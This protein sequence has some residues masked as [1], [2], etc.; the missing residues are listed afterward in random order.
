MTETHSRNAPLA[1]RDLAHVW[2][3]CTQMREHEAQLPLIPIVRGDGAWLVDA[4]G[5]RYLDGISSWWSCLFGH[6]NPRI[7]AAIAG[8]AA[9]LN[10]VMLAGFTHEPALQLAEELVRIAP[11]GLTRVSYASDGASA[12]EIALKMSFHYWRNA[13]Q[14]QRT[15]F[16]ALANAYHGETLGALAVSDLPLYREVYGPL[17][18]D[19]IVAPSPDWLDAEP[20]ESA[21]DVAR[22]RLVD[23]RA[24]LERHAHETCAVIV[25]PLVQCSGG[26]RMHAP[27]YLAGLRA[28]CDE[29]DV[30]LIADEIAVGF[31]RTGTLFACGQAAITP[32]FLCLSKGLTGGAL[33]LS[34]VLTT[35]TVY[36]AFLGNYADNNAFLHS[37][38]FSGNPIAC[39]AALASLSIFRDEPVLE[40]NRALAAH[41]AMRLRP[42][43]EH[44]HVANL[45]QTGWI[46]AFDL[47]RD[48]ATR[49]A[50]PSEERRG[51]RF[52]THALERGVLL[53]PL[54]DTVYFLPPYCI[55]SNDVDF[56]VDAAISAI[57]FATA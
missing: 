42:L 27:A 50:W 13:G 28:L 3:P 5:R 15:R 53:R 19:P 4:D 36:D 21:D 6:A 20:G 32:D 26:M 1:A 49:T 39:A 45:R 40:R 10:H 46:A 51:R 11:A 18:F 8:Q 55:D 12:V 43:A 41:L 29:F 34:A 9:R 31:G 54:G 22:R 44:P 37:H 35:D 7:A 24:L 47:V 56:M 25:E 16:I 30:P 14:P 57:E 48:K 2:H 17:L 23:M 33:P 38:T 52:Y